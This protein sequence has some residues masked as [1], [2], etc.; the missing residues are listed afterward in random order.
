MILPWELAIAATRELALFAA[1]CFL[2]GG[3][4]ELV[5]DLIWIC[6]TLWRR[7]TVYRIH[8]RA[9]AASVLTEDDGRVTAIFIPAWD[10]SRV[11]APM[12]RAALA[13]L[14]SGRFIIYVGLYPNDAATIA[15]VR[16]VASDR[17]RA[18]IGARPGPSTK[19]DCL[20]NIWQA[21]VSDEAAG[22]EAFRAVVLHDAEDVI[23][24]RELKVFAALI[25]RFDLV[26]LPVMPLI[27]GNSRWI[28]GHYGDEFAESHAK[29]IVVREALGAGIPAA[30][31]GCAMSREM[32][33]RIAA[34]RGG[35]PFDADSLT[36]D[37][38]LGLRVAE[39]GGRAAF[40]RMPAQPGGA[41][42]AVRAHF[43]ATIDAAVRQK[44]RWMT[45]IALN[46]WDRLG[47]SGGW[48]E[49]WM[50]LRDRRAPI[51][52][53]ALFAAYTAL[54]LGAICAAGPIFGLRAFTPSPLL[55]ALIRINLIL[56]VWRLACR[57]AFVTRDYGWRE[58][59]RSIP[60]M[61]IG[62]VIAM[63]AARRALGLYIGSRRDGVVRWDKTGHHF[64]AVI[65]AE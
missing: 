51:A 58:G 36:E 7:A 40:V 11:I 10:E 4:D 55:G 26:Q 39:F 15:A 42:V 53:L 8:M 5:I 25:G 1:V 54:A 23:H 32:L 29:A 59:A 50:R 61:V 31:V 2:I 27:D 3:I 44:A 60:R 19:A 28:G 13:R 24:S 9:D 56:L 49:S 20:N 38:E 52:A 65:P 45:G 33:D 6:R 14:G 35:A 21:M 34:A 43:P 16:S 46:G 41:I 18:V 17:V 64:P 48:A 37:Y 47:W 62:N 30:G 22:G 12:L 57:F 63:M